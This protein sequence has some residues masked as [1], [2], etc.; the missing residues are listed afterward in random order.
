LDRFSDTI[1]EDGIVIED[2]K[3]RSRVVWE[4][5]AKLLDDPVR[6][7]VLRDTEVEELTSAVSDHE[8]DVQE[9]ESD[10][11]NDQEVHRRDPVPVIPKEGAPSLALIAVGISFREISRDRG[12]AN[13]DSELLEL[14]VNL[15]SAPA[16][17][18]GESPNEC[19][20]LSRNR[21]PTRSGL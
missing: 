18:V 21:G 10:G 12:E 16:I 19:S 17:L 13:E 7:R 14:G 6:G 11:W 4:G 8:P 2:E 3:A 5:L 15:S 1:R 9:P 20:R